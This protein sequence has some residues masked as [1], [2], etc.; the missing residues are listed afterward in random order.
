MKNILEVRSRIAGV[1]RRKHDES[2]IILFVALE[3][4]ANRSRDA[5]G[6]LLIVALSSVSEAALLHEASGLSVEQGCIAVVAGLKHE[7]LPDLI[8]VADF[9][10]AAVEGTVLEGLPQ[11]GADDV[12]HRMVGRL[13]RL[14]SSLG[15]VANDPK[16]GLVGHDIDVFDVFDFVVL[17]K[18]GVEDHFL[19]ALEGSG[20]LMLVKA[21]LEVHAHHGEVLAGV[22]E[23][24]VEG[25]VSVGGGLEVPEY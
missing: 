17:G 19:Q 16:G 12:D 6:V 24:D 18:L 21:E 11:N 25:G 2:R 15:R 23:G 14:R 9:V 20:G 8:E 3:S 7:S 4:H 22:G 10:Q 5:F 1:A 13:P